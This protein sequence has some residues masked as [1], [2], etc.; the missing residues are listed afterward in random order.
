MTESDAPIETKASD[1]GKCPLPTT[2][3]RL[4]EAHLLWHQSLDKYQE[5]DAFRANLNATIQALDEAAAVLEPTFDFAPPHAAE[6]EVPTEPAAQ[7]AAESATSQQVTS[8]SDDLDEEMSELLKESGSSGWT[9]NSNPPVN[10]RQSPIRAASYDV[11][12]AAQNHSLRS[13][14]AGW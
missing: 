14:S 3:R 1:Y 6:Q 2:H 8:Q 5:P 7:P 4:A 9:R 10:S 13:D 11:I 12:W